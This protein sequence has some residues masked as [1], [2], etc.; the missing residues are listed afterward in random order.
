MSFVLSHEAPLSGLLYDTETAAAFSI[1]Q[2][3]HA[4][5]RFERALARAQAKTGVISNE[6]CKAIE[7]ALDDF[8]I[9]PDDLTERTRRDGLLSPGLVAAVRA[10][11]APPHDRAFHKG[12]TSQDL[13]DTSLMLRL[14]ALL[15]RFAGRLETIVD[16]LAAHASNAELMAHT[17][18]QVA[19]PITVSDKI[20]IWQRPLKSALEQVPTV[21]PLQL[22]GPVGNGEALADDFHALANLMAS[23]LG[24]SAR[25]ASW[26]TDRTPLLTIANWAL[27]VTTALGK[28]GQ[29]VALLSQNEI[30]AVRLAGGGSS[31]AMAHKSNPILA[32]NLVTLA[33]FNATMIGGLQQAA[34][35]ENERSG[36][37]W[38]LEWMLF[39]Q[40]I[41]ATGTAL[42]NGEELV[43][44]LSFP[45]PG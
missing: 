5:L 45:K 31:S 40:L 18:M 20:S 43:Q 8:T 11:V 41:I 15:P 39:P 7:T 44:K 17:R 21:F 1:K 36:V 26:H 23:E 6:A 16:G 10:T 12:T 25:E 30:G 27:S 35:H 38:T 29:D 33:R 4:Q 13:I 32:E 22:G 37:A 19:L 34:L 14:K 9:D 42:R 24:L 3:I 28:I 2:D